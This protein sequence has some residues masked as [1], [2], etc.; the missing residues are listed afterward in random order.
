MPVILI[1]T[2]EVL[3]FEAFWKFKFRNKF[4]LVVFKQYA[5]PEKLYYLFSICKHIV[6]AEMNWKYSSAISS[7]GPS[8]HR[9]ILI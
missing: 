3:I 2:I 1:N 9:I 6:F 8:V 7:S 5:I 4:L